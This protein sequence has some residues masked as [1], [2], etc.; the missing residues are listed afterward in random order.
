M[1]KSMLVFLILAC[2]AINDPPRGFEWIKPQAR[3]IGW[4]LSAALD[5]NN[6]LPQLSQ[7]GR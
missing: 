6:L 3:T 1:S 7:V 2:A 5:I 4:K